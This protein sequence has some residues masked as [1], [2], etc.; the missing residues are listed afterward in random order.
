M[1]QII[2]LGSV[3]IV[4]SCATRVVRFEQ[5]SVT[6]NLPV[7]ADSSVVIGNDQ[8]FS[9]VLWLNT[10]LKA[11]NVPVEKIKLIQN[12]GRYFL[13]AENF[14]HVWLIE[15]EEDGL[16]GEF[17]AIDVTPK[18]KADRYTDIGFSRYGTREHACVK[19]RFNKQEVFINR[20]GNVDE[21]CNK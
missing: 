20:K 4:L 21:K 7:A 14:Q 1:K 6:M 9:G 2:F 16:S 8:H 13:C 12:Y 15:P 11:E 18:D 3:L 17:K 19:F 5:Y 10:I